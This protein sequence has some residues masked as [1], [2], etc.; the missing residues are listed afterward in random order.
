MSEPIESQ[1]KHKQIAL[2]LLISANDDQNLINDDTIEAIYDLFSD[3]KFESQGYQKR[4][5]KIITGK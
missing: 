4:L 5:E 2:D 1:S 3:E